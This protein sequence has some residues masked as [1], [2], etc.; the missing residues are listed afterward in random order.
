MGSRM[1]QSE[2]LTHESKPAT[3]WLTKTDSVWQALS[4]FSAIGFTLLNPMQK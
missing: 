2:Q 1:Q 3:K 4:V